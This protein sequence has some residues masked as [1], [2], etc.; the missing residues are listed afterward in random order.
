MCSN[1]EYDMGETKKN[2]QIKLF[3]YPIKSLSAHH[4]L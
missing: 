1:R 2:I 3:E 4:C